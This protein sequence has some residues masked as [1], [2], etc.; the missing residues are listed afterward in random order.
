MVCNVS[1]CVCVH[2]DTNTCPRSFCWTQ[3][4]GKQVKGGSKTTDIHEMGGAL[5]LKMKI[6][7]KVA[8]KET[9]A[10][11][12][13]SKIETKQN[14]ARCAEKETFKYCRVFGKLF[15]MSKLLK[16]KQQPTNKAQKEET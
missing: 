7:E 4:T 16:A 9:K 1:V 12:T 8:K 11:E 10:R 13:K 2:T 14:K 6:N 15:H 5:D 3:L